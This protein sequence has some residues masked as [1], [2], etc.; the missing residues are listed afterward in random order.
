MKEAIKRENDVIDYGHE[1]EPR[2][3]SLAVYKFIS[4]PSI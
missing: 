2:Q 3:S 4:I 1:H